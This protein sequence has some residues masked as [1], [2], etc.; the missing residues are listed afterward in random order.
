[1]AKPKRARPHQR[2]TSYE[3][4][5]EVPATSLEE[6]TLE[7][8]YS[9]QLGALLLVLAREIDEAEGHGMAALCRVYLDALRAR[10]DADKVKPV[11]DE[12]DEIIGSLT[13]T[14]A[15]RLSVV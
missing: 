8:D 11:T 12:V 7:G 5:P 3:A 2:A 10:R 9:D 4:P 14:H 15:R 13:D 1:M 6:A